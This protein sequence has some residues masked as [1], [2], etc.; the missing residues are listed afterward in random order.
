MM[1]S[2]EN[3]HNCHFML[4]QNAKGYFTGNF[5]CSYCGIKVSQSQWFDN[6]AI[7]AGREPSHGLSRTPP[8]E[9]R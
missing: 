9:N 4:E 7:T 5:V 2:V 3:R 6:L 8:R 1:G